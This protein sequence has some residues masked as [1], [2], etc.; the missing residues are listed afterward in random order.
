MLQGKAPSEEQLMKI[1]ASVLQS[2]L[3][4]IVLIF[5]LISVTN[6]LSDV[7]MNEKMKIKYADASI[8][9]NVCPYLWLEFDKTP[10]CKY[11]I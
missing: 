9:F 3:S 11:Y 2:K 8:T 6:K 4:C 5:C 1:C 10:N 7:E